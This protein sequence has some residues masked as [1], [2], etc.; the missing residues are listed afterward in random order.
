M[1]GPSRDRSDPVGVPT[2]ALRRACHG[3]RSP[4]P[5]GTPSVGVLVPEALAPFG[6]G[7]RTRGRSV[8]WALHVCS[9][10]HPDRAVSSG[11]V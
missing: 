1:G 4:L 10:F 6:V 7:S 11:G 9:G 2:L 5:L 8:L 3:V